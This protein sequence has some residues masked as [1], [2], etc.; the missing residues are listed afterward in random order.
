[1]TLSDCSFG[2]YLFYF[3]I[4]RIFKTF[5]HNGKYNSIWWVP[6]QAFIIY[7]ICLIIIYILR[8]ILIF[9]VITR[10]NKFIYLFILINK[11]K[12]LILNI[13]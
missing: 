9:K 2:I 4:L 11:K 1:M 12:Y 10:N 7:F 8:K 13:T 3:N 6:T 5:I